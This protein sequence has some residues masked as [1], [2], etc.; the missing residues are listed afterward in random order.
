MDH[1]PRVIQGAA[2]TNIVPRLDSAA[3]VARSASYPAP[4]H[5]G[6]QKINEMKAANGQNENYQQQLKAASTELLDD[7]RVD[8]GSKAGRSILNV[9]MKTEQRL[10]KQRRAALHKKRLD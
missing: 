7:H 3:S 9:L 4:A 2:S 10:R 8:I 1:R 5:G 6:S